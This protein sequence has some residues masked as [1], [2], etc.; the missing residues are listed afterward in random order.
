LE[1]NSLRSSWARIEKYLN[2]EAPSLLETLNPPAS[3]EKLFEFKMSMPFELPEELIE[4]YRI[5]EG[6]SFPSIASFAYGLSFYDLERLTYN[7]AFY[8]KASSGVDPEFCDIGIKKEW[9]N[10]PLRVPLGD[11][12]SRCTI[13]VDLDPSEEGVIGQIVL[14]D[15]DFLVA[16]KLAN[17]IS[18]MYYEFA[19]DLENGRYFLDPDALSDGQEILEPEKELDVINWQN[20]ARWKNIL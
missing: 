17:S 16:L 10:S 7:Q 14:F 11:D 20:I 6:V 19:N 15:G 13:C 12:G 18:E 9:L 1:Y 3:E 8:Q 4:L 2:K 5:H